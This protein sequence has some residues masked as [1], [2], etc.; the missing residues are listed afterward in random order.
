M[1]AKNVYGSLN[2]LLFQFQKV[3]LWVSSFVL[4][5][6]F[7]LI[8]IPKGAIM[9]S[10]LPERINTKAKIS[11]PKGAIMRTSGN[12]NF[13]AFAPFQFQK[14]R[15]WVTFDEE[16][17]SKL[18]DFNSKRCDYECICKCCNWC[19]KFYFN[20]KRC[21]YEASWRNEKSRAKYISIPKGAIMS[22]RRGEIAST[23][24]NFNSKRCDY[25]NLEN[26][27]FLKI[28]NFNSKRCDYEFWP[29]I[30][31][32]CIS[33]FNS[34]RCDYEPTGIFCVKSAMV[35]SIPKGAIMRLLKLHIVSKMMWI[36]IPKGA[37]M[38]L[39]WIWRW[40]EGWQISIPKGAIMSR[41]VYIDGQRYLLF[42]F[43]KVRLWADTSTVCR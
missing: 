3:R 21:D 41:S 2:R 40:S 14:V 36:S 29:S 37:I 19:S 20:S 39:S 43:Q 4:G 16:E 26:N 24:G 30:V 8:S 5:S 11:I 9:S 27:E 18:C 42:Q 34:K 17:L 35:I 15:L 10:N 13:R 28:A 12:T 1:S 7:D 38:S 22:V 31:W 33:Y 6:N 32:A 23:F 25:E